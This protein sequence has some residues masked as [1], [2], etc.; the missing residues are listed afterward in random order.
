MNFSIL[1][2][3]AVAS[4]L[5]LS[6]CSNKDESSVSNT[7][8][9]S[10]QSAPT[11]HLYVGHDTGPVSLYSL[12]EFS[13]LTEIAVGEPPTSQG[14]HSLALSEDG[15]L[16]AVA[17]A[18]AKALAIVDTN[19]RQTVHSVLLG[20]EPSLVQVHGMTAVVAHAPLQISV[21]DLPTGE[22]K[23]TFNVAIEP[24]NM[25][26]ASNGQHLVAT[27]E[28]FDELFVYDLETGEPVQQTDVSE[29]GVRPRGVVQS[30]DGKHLALAMEYSNKVLV[31]NSEYKVVDEVLTGEVP[32]AV[33]YNQTGSELVVA[34]VRGKVIQVFDT[35]TLMLKRELPVGAQCLRF[36]FTPEDTHL[37][38]ACGLANKLAVLNYAT[39]ELVREI[40][41]TT[42]PRGLAVSLQ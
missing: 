10:A 1:R 6:A 34:L 27:H 42:A 26:I 7:V 36:A 30:P 9:P 14:G 21:I 28:N 37:I 33:A 11:G 22:I 4:V 29:Y 20:S 2:N 23:R 40:E 15:K 25:A 39:G 12:A 3:L 17:V 16:L 35:D 5:L 8:A 24:Q 19:T 31:L 38:V 13:K 18:Q 32:Y 41:Q